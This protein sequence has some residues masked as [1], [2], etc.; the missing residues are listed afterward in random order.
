MKILHLEK[1]HEI[2]AEMLENAGCVNSFD[3]TSSREEIMKKI[4]DYQGI[5][6]RSRFPV[7][8]DFLKAATSLKCI[9]RVGAGLENIDLITAKE[10]GIQCYNA[11]EGNR[12]AVAEHAIGMLLALMNKMRTAHLEI[13]K[14]KWNRE[15]NRG[16]E[17]EGKTIGI[18]GYGNMGKAFAQ[19]LSGFNAQVI[20][21]DIQK[22]IQDSYAQPVSLAELQERSDIISLH[23]PQTDQTIGMIDRAFIEGCAK[24]FFLI[25]T[26][27]GSAV[28]TDD[29]VE[30]I[31]N[32]LIKGAALDVLEY[33][34]SSFSSL[35][36]DSKMPVAFEKLLRFDNVLLSPH[37]AGWTEESKVKLAQVIA[38]KIIEHHLS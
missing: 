3:Y 13:Q 29:L 10:L 30:A 11:P 23:T 12:V 4:S 33:E 5:V 32:G 24:P 19:R 36:N 31:E 35:F 22:E 15:S 28:V 18:I 34:K 1:N 21:Y 9:G 8:R 26:A 25:N 2:L 38:Q 17:I 16:L 20:F 14:G 6:I 7:D 27:R 37:V